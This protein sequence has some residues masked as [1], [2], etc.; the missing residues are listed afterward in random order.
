MKLAAWETTPRIV[1]LGGAS[2]SVHL[3]RIIGC[4]TQSRARGASRETRVELKSVA[5]FLGIW[6]VST[7]IVYHRQRQEL[8]RIHE[9]SESPMGPRGAV[10]VC[11]LLGLLISMGTMVLGTFIWHQFLA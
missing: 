3:L 7:L 5:V 9:A 4:A 10:F 2:F 11:A 1:S 8:G 6:L